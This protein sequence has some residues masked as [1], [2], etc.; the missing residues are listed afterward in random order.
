MQPKQT[1]SKGGDCFACALTALLTHLFPEKKVNFETVW[2]YFMQKSHSGK[3]VLCNDWIGMQRAIEKAK[4]E[5]FDVEKQLYIVKPDFDLNHSSHC[6]YHFYPTGDFND[7]LKERLENGWI[8][9]QE[10]NYSGA[11]AINNEGRTSSNDHFVIVD[12]VRE[13]WEPENAKFRQLIYYVHVV[14]SAKGTYWI[15]TEDFVKKH[16]AAGWILVRRN[17]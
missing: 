2:N 1:K 10:I 5:G 16:G 12:G 7:T 11:Y 17:N 14:C 15:K 3:D 4:Q 9:L 13:A 8:A 6:F